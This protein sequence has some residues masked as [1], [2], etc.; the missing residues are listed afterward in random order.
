MVPEALTSSAGPG[1]AAL[2][3]G[4]LVMLPKGRPW[5]TEEEDS[6]LLLLSDGDDLQF[7]YRSML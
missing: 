7:K 6:R 5:G 4:V 1:V 3:A 2:E